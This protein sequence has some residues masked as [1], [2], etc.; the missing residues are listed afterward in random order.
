MRFPTAAALLALLP[1]FACRGALTPAEGA[2]PDA[3]T[4]RIGDVHW[5]VDYDA[6]LAVAREQDKAM[7]MHFGENPG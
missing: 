5:Y 6:A 2:G 7:W 3:G 4:V 1:A